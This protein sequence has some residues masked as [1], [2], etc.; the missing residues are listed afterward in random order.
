VSPR[1]HR[2]LRG[3]LVASTATAVAAVSHGL[4]GGYVPALPS[5]VLGLVF[6]SLTS[7]ALAGR[8]SRGWR[9]A[10]SVAISQLAFHT[11]FATLGTD[12]TI[13][14]VGHHGAAVVSAAGHA[15]TADPLMWLAHVVAGVATA[16]LLRH[17]ETALRLI[18]RA[19]VPRRAGKP[20]PSCP[21]D[22]PRPAALPSLPRLLDRV[23]SVR[24]LRGPPTVLA[25]H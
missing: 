11:L 3:L 1:V 17:G 5:L 10:A 15:H 16:A 21:G 7:V 22:S 14:V 19:L 4:V 20:A 8:R 24:S 9:V 12:A 6:A 25:A 23:L 2:T 18:R 13:T